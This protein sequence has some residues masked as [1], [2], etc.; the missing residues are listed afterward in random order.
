MCGRQRG[1][2][3]GHAPS[4]SPTM[5]TSH[6]S[7]WSITISHSSQP[8]EQRASQL[9]SQPCTSIRVPAW[10]GRRGRK[11]GRGWR[12]QGAKGEEREQ[13]LIRSAGGSGVL[14]ER[15]GQEV[16][17]AELEERGLRTSGENVVGTR[18]RGRGSAGSAQE[19]GSAPG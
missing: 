13:G 9:G 11:R 14:A 16:Q 3:G 15:A 7:P 5:H 12:D 10:D 18:G 17:T 6:V 1:A 4:P 2:G 8:H 19:Q